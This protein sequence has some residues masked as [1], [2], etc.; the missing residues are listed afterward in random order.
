M[1]SKLVAGKYSIDFIDKIL[2]IED[3]SYEADP[4]TVSNFLYYMKQNDVFEKIKGLW[5]GYYEH[6]SGIA[7]EKIVMDV[8]EDEYNFPIIKSNNFGHC[9]TKTVIP[10]GTKARID[11][12]KD[13]K[14]ELIEE[15]VQK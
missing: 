12:T 7:L 1:T 8:L 10:I 6:E 2:F 13:V 9:E 4:A 15:C 11:T 5:I 3:F 14:I